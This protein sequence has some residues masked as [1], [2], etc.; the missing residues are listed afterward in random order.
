MKKKFQLFY[1]VVVGSNLNVKG[2][3]KKTIPTKTANIDKYI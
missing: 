2:N 1:G 3:Y